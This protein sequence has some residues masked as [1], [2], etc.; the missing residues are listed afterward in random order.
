MDKEQGIIA[1]VLGGML[2]DENN[3]QN[4]MVLVLLRKHEKNWKVEHETHEK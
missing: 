2:V 3:L 4:I 1:V